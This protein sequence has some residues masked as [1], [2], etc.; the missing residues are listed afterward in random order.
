MQQP[1]ARPAIEHS[2]AFEGSVAREMRPGEHVG[3]ALVDPFEMGADDRFGRER[4]GIDLSRAISVA[5]SVFGAG[6]VA[7]MS[8][9]KR[10]AS[11]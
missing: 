10:A 3:V 6:H 5:V 11:I 7:H 9:N 1:L 8:S 4:A 2:G